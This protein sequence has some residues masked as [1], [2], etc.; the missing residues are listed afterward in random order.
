MNTS[1]VPSLTSDHGYYPQTAH[2]DFARNLANTA[3]GHELRKL[4][5]IEY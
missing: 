3:V 1:L 2:L 4:F 5:G